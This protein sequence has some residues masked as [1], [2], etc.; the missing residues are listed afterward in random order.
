MFIIAF[1]EQ[2]RSNPCPYCGRT[3]KPRGLG[4]H[5]R[6]AHGVKIKTVVRTVVPHNSTT[7]PHNSTTV[8]HNSTIVPDNST[9]VQRPS[10][11][12]KKRSEII[13]TRVDPAIKNVDINHPGMSVIS[14]RGAWIYAEMCKRKNYSIEC[15][16]ELEKIFN[17]KNPC[18]IGCN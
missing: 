5:I 12:V 3:F 1:M 17:D 13:E 11:Y 18:Y 10:D 16:R 4:T 7:V 2:V 9:V 15:Y 6:E 8:T 14:D